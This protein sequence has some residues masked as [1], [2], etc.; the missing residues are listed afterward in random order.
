MRSTRNGFAAL[1]SVSQCAA[2]VAGTMAVDRFAVVTLGQLAIPAAEDALAALLTK[3]RVLSFMIPWPP[4][5]PR[6]G[7]TGVTSIVAAVIAIHESCVPFGNRTGPAHPLS[8]NVQGRVLASTTGGHEV[9]G[10][11]P[12]VEF[13]WIEPGGD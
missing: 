4:S 3:R 12:S 6:N 10:L 13:Q 2:F 5:I 9:P 8:A 11:P 7:A 1:A